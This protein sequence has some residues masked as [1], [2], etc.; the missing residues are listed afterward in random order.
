LRPGPARA[1]LDA[2]DARYAQ[3]GPAGEAGRRGRDDRADED[4][5][6]RRED[7][8]V[9]RDRRAAARRPDRRAVVPG[10]VVRDLDQIEDC[11]SHLLEDVLAH[12]L[13]MVRDAED[14][15][16]VVRADPAL[17]ELPEDVWQ[18]PGALGRPREVVADDGRGLLAAG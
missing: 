5:Q 14:D 2:G 17:A 11:L 7:V 12:H 1:G 6:V 13:A 9:E 18:E 4:L 16:D 8:A 3:L 15:P 10:E